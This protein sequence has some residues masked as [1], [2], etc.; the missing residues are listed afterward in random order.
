MELRG[1]K[2]TVFGAAAIVEVVLVAILLLRRF[3]QEQ[4]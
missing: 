3:P 2:I 1:I 4:N